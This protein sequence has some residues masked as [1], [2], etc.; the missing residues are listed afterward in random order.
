[1]C[2]RYQNI[3]T[4]LSLWA[5]KFK[6]SI[7]DD[8]ENAAEEF[9]PGAPCGVIAA[10][11]DLEK[12]VTLA[13]WGLIPAWSKD[14]MFGKKSTYNA[15]SETIAEKPSFK[16]AF[17]TRRCLIPATSF[18]ERDNGRWLEFRIEGKETFAIAGL[19]ELPNNTCANISYAMVTS[20][21]NSAVSAVHDRAPVVL[22]LYDAEVWL[23]QNSSHAELKNVLKPFSETLF[24]WEDAG[25]VG[26]GSIN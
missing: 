20:E 5:A 23:N 14:P 7:P 21:P 3:K 9:F 1:M 26:R 24:T 15:R 12:K 2:V 10:Q 22:T 11:S 13:Q 25:P 4:N 19:Y 16:E 18:F 8:L 17:K 6:F